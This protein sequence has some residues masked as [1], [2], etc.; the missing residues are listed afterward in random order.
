MRLWLV[1]AVGCAGKEEAPPVIEDLDA[2]GAPASQD[3]DDRDEAVHPGAEELCDGL[4]NDCDGEIDEDA[5]DAETFFE[6]LDGDGAG[7]YDTTRALCAAEP[8]WAAQGGDCDDDDAALHPGAPELCN[9]L[10]D[11]CNPTTPEVAQL[12]TYAFP[13]IKEAID[14]AVSGDVVTVCAGEHPFDS[15]VIE[16]ELTVR[17][18][19]GDPGDVILQASGP[20]KMIKVLAGTLTVEGL[21]FRGAHSGV[22][23][24]YPESGGVLEVDPALEGA[25][26]VRACVF[27]DNE[28]S[29]G[30]PC[31]SGHVMSIED[32]TFRRND[33]GYSYGCIMASGEGPLAISGSTFEDNRGI[34]G[35]LS[36]TVPTTIEGGIFLENLSYYSGALEVSSTDL[37]LSGVTF[38]GN[39]GPLGA[40]LWVQALVAPVDVTADSATTFVENT[41]SSQGGAVYLAVYAPV[42]WSGGTFV[43]N[44][45]FSGGAMAVAAGEAVEVSGVEMTDNEATGSGGGLYVEFAAG[46]QPDL[47]TVRDSSLVGNLAARGG[48]MAT[49][50]FTL[51]PL[52]DRIELTGVR[53]AQNTATV[54]GGALYLEPQVDVPVA[55]SA[56][57]LGVGLDDNTPDDITV[58]TTALSGLG[59]DTSLVCS[60][61]DSLCE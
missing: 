13:T 59:E 8:G 52:S 53:F 24:A 51:N 23:G 4:D 22:V 38:Q 19:T 34:V 11:D 49:G 15:V 42:T 55:L 26:I 41:A 56:C 57:D 5:A 39:E 17:G 58:G 7:T 60:P 61:G 44:R 16:E 1:L 45:A 10:D 12:G 35:A 21:T 33:G 46:N 31:I 14:V 25:S 48:G 28:A 50:L 9:G 18:A 30:G 20:G 2:D 27:E 37:G 36:T 54:Q 6:D 47:V 29:F 3:C 40:A 32:S 43:G